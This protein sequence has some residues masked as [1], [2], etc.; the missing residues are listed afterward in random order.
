MKKYSLLF[1]ILLVNMISFGQ[2]NGKMNISLQEKLRVPANTERVISVLVKG[3]IDIIKRLAVTYGGAFNYSAGDIACISIKLKFIPDIAM[4]PYIKRIEANEGNIQPLND[5]MLVNNRVTSINDGT[6]LGQDYDG[7]GVV[8]GVID[9]GIDWTHPD[10]K[11]LDSTSR[12]KFIWDQRQNDS[13]NTPLPYNYG[14]EWNN[15]DITLGFCT[16][17]DNNNNSHGTICTGIA[18]GNGLCCGNY[19]GVAPKADIIFVAIDFSN[20]FNTTVEDAVNYIFAKADALN[21][22]CVINASIG[23]YFGSHDGMDLQAQY[24]N[25]KI[26]E[27]NGR[28]FVCAAG[29][30]GGFPFHVGYD[31]QPNDTTFTWLSF[32]N[33]NFIDIWA[34]TANFNNIKFSIG[35]DTIDLTNNVYAFK[36][37]SVYRNG[38]SILSTFVQDTIWSPYDSI[39]AVVQSVCNLVGGSYNYRINIISHPGSYY[40]R[41]SATDTASVSAHFDS[42]DFNFVSNNLPSIIT[43]PPIVNYKAPDTW[44]TICSSF[45]CSDKVLTVGSYNNRNTYTDDCNPDNFHYLSG[46]I[47]GDRSGFSSNGPS[48]EGLIK[49]DI[50]SPGEWVISSAVLSE[51]AFLNT[52]GCTNGTCKVA[53]GACNILASGT[54]M[55]SPSVAGIAALYFQRFPNASWQDLKN[56]IINNAKI[57]D[58]LTGSLPNNNWGYGKIDACGTLRCTSNVVNNFHDPNTMLNNFPNPFNNETTIAYDIHQLSSGIKGEIVITDILGNEIKSMPIYTNQGKMTFDRGELQSGLYFYSLKIDGRALI[59][60]KMVIL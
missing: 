52:I 47:I 33:S 48:R 26:T 20:N 58:T 2:I 9:T 3:D 36:G 31:V 38:N 43:F 7:S 23:N 42:W 53:P 37:S 29:N 59:T 44:Q 14:Q 8:I 19:R 27:K 45:Q 54:S 10:F 56:C 60:K 22:P 21:E 55:A 49:P 17:N 15:I 4:N 39:I 12:I 18:A 34:D 57:A 28:A 30:E 35:A 50:M 5:H 13:T 32:P 1:V 40:F 24:I 6:C 25:N 46:I 51:M 16:S 11:N 41:L